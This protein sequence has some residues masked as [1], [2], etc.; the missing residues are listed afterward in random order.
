ME[1]TQRTVSNESRD[2]ADQPIGTPFDD[3]PLPAPYV[4]GQ[5]KVSVVQG[6]NGRLYPA[7]DTPLSQCPTNLDLTTYNGKAM[8][9]AAG[10][11][12]D[13]EFSQNGELKVLATHYLI[14]PEERPDPDTGE[15]SQFARTVLFQA[16]GR[17][18]RTTAAHAPHRI[19]AAL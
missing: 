4:P 3:K 15:I 1:N 13:L 9:M 10:N 14:F 2:V 5:S 6:H 7:A 17:I 11:P 16:D 18:F 12:S 19:Q 8:A